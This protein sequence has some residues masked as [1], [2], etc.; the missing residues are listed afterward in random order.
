M[1]IGTNIEMSKVYAGEAQIGEIYRGSELIYSAELP[2]VSP[3]TITLYSGDPGIG[4]WSNYSFTDYF[5]LTGYSKLTGRLNIHVHVN[6]TTTHGFSGEAHL[7]LVDSSGIFTPIGYVN[8]GSNFKGDYYNSAN[9]NHSVSGLNGT[10][11]IAL[12][13]SNFRE[14]TYVAA[15]G[16]SAASVENLMLT[17]E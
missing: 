15:D 9:I 10:Y 12:R 3:S 17:N 6:A 4:Y 7:Y 11:R 14:N 1:S 13:N 8:T 2:V 16:Y 5:D